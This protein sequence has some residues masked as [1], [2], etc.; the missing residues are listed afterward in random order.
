MGAQIT[1]KSAPL[2]AGA[3][4]TPPGFRAAARRTTR[5]H[6][7]RR[8]VGPGAGSPCPRRARACYGES[9]RISSEMRPSPRSKAD[10]GRIDVSHGGGRAAHGAPVVGPPGAAVEGDE[11][12]RD[13]RHAGEGRDGGR[14]RG[15]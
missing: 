1:K 2:A 5:D 14:L 3:A 11:P 15:L 12:L 7:I 4:S 13:P 10:A 8:I 9:W 6:T